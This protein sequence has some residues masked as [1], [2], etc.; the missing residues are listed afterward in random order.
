M[1]TRT[2]FKFCLVVG[3]I[4]QFDNWE[5]KRVLVVTT[6]KMLTRRYFTDACVLDL[7][8]PAVCAMDICVHAVCVYLLKKD[9]C[10]RQLKNT[11]LF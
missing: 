1:K 6:Y 10:D 11:D 2:S 9:I 4:D 3:F 8:D 5:V 7:C